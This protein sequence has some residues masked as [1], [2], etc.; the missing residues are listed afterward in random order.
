MNW[1]T[2][3]NGVNYRILSE[4]GAGEVTSIEYD[5]RKVKASG[6]FVAV[7]GGAFDGH[8]FLQ[9]A[10]EAGAVLA[11]IER[12][13]PAYPDNM[14]VL[15]VKS[16]LEAMPVMAVNFYEKP[17]ESMEMIGVTGT[18]GKTTDYN[19]DPQDFNGVSA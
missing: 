12:E 11:V 1:K 4:G 7:S 6:A 5:S 17:S 19:A 8:D 9:N 18:K 16:T 15:L 10:A 14:T 13:L 2:L 3:M